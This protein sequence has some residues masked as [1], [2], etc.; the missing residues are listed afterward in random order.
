MKTIEQIMEEMNLSRNWIIDLIKRIETYDQEG[1]LQEW[2]DV[3]HSMYVIR[4]HRGK[5][6]LMM[7]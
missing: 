1:I 2:I 5:G 7:N 3:I 6:I 4:M